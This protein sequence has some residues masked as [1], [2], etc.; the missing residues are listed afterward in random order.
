MANINKKSK[1][2]AGGEKGFTGFSE[3]YLGRL[4]NRRMSYSEKLKRWNSIK[5]ILIFIGIAAVFVL[6]FIFTE[7]MLDISQRPVETTA[8]HIFLYFPV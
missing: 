5:W 2:E 6:A 3:T 4:N 1:T 8:G 7:V